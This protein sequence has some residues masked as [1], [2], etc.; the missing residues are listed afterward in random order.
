MIARLIM[1]NQLVAMHSIYSTWFVFAHKTG[2]L[3]HDRPIHSTMWQNIKTS[4]L[5]HQNDFHFPSKFIFQ[6]YLEL[7]D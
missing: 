2:S 6:Q 4:R 5:Q 1:L 3:V 7:R